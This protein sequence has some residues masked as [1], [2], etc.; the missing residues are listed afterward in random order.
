[1]KNRKSLLSTPRAGNI[2]HAQA[3][4]GASLICLVTSI[5]QDTI[6]AR[7]VTSHETLEF[8]RVT[9]L[10]K[11]AE[12]EPVA[13]INS[14]KPLPPEVHDVFV[15]LDRKYG[16]VHGKKEVFEQNPEYFRLSKTEKDALL[17]IDTHYSSN[18]LPPF[19]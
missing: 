8:D 11:V 4:N 18:L 1:M 3:P 13:V 5:S 17:F 7:R 10:E 19:S 6:Q 14:I 2:F 15:A 16:A 9:G 12:G